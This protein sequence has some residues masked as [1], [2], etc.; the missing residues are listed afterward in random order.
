MQC[1][2]VVTAEDLHDRIN[3]GLRCRYCGVNAHG[4]C[5]CYVVVVRLDKTDRTL[6][7]LF[8]GIAADNDIKLVILRHR[9][10]KIG[11]P[12]AL[13][14]PEVL[15]GDRSVQDKYVREDIAELPADILIFLHKGDVPVHFCRKLHEKIAADPCGTDK[16]YPLQGEGGVR[17]AEVAVHIF[18]LTIIADDR[19][20]IT[21]I[22]NRRAGWG[23]CLSLVADTGDEI[24][25]GKLLLYF[26]EVFTCKHAAFVHT[27][28]EYDI[29]CA[30]EI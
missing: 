17:N 24:A 15:I 1:P 26:D 8:L 27:C 30:R 29:M 25:S 4:A 7:A 5:Q 3:R 9:D 11:I 2:D 28:R 20:L 21:F 14:I 23:E 6:R 16:N 12:Y 13:L 10:E 19:D 18:P 22:Q